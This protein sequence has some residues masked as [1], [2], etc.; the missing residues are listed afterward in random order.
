[1]QNLSRDEPTEDKPM[2]SDLDLAL[3]RFKERRISNL[4]WYVMLLGHAQRFVMFI[5]Q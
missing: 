3:K 1:V 2:S 4:I 5:E